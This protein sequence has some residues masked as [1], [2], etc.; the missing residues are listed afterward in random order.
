MTTFFSKYN[1]N[2]NENCKCSVRKLC[3]SGD[4]TDKLGRIP[5]LFTII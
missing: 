2:N 4:G 3:N 5:T 1:S